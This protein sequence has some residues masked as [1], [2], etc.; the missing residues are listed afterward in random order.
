LPLGKKKI[1]KNIRKII[2]NIRLRFRRPAAFFDRRSGN[3]GIDFIHLA[4]H[5]GPPLGRDGPEFVLHNLERERP[6]A[7]L[8]DSSHGLSQ[9]TT[10]CPFQQKAREGELSSLEMVPQ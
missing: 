5:L 7:C 9:A 1:I 3:Q 4:D 2:K 8:R 10:A 6:K